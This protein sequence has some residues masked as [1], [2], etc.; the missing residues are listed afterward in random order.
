MAKPKK[1]T[2]PRKSVA[3]PTPTGLNDRAR[4]A[5]NSKLKFA[6]MFGDSCSI[7]GITKN[8]DVYCWN[9]LTG[10]WFRNWDFDGSVR[11]NIAVQQAAQKLADETTASNNPPGAQ[12]PAN[13]NGA[14]RR[15]PK[16]VGEAAAA[17]GA[18]DALG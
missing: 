5:A 8:N 10:E 17:H 9:A 12:A 14:A 1:K 7:F 6:F 16:T 18:I 11:Q 3:P 4:T 13:I 15:T 2:A